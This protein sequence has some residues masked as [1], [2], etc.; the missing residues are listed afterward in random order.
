MKSMSTDQWFQV[1]LSKL[2]TNTRKQYIQL[3]EAEADV[4]E[5]ELRKLRLK[6][7]QQLI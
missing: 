6:Q 3:L 5:L 4:A 1:L 7:Q 2:I